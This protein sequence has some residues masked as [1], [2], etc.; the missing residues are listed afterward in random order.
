MKI[1]IWDKVWFYNLKWKIE[2]ITWID[3]EHYYIWTLNNWWWWNDKE[4]YKL[5]K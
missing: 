4:I 1:K 2:S 3:G 5:S